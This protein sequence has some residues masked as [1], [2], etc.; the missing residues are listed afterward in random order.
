MRKTTTFRRLLDRTGPT[1]IPGVYDALSAAIAQETGFDAVAITGAGLSVTHGYPDLG[2][3]T[4]TEVVERAR[5]VVRGTSLPVLVD[6]DTG[7]GGVLNIERTVREFEAVGVAALHLEDQVTQ[8][9]CG[10]LEGIQVVSVEQMTARVRAAVAARSDPDF[11]VVARTDVRACGQLADVITRA[12][13]YRAAGADAIFL[14]DLHSRAELEVAAREIPGPKITHVSRGGRVA[15]IPPAELADMGYQAICYPL[16]PLQ[17][18]A[19]ALRTALV[20][21]RDDASLEPLYDR[22]VKPVELYELVGLTR[23]QEFARD[24][25]REEA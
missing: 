18:A 3:M 21:L 14:F 25:E 19:H 11:C 22:M 6:A 17:A 8:K 7:Y 5:A 9:R 10:L 12:H 23:A 4:L 2:L 24:Y 13:A 1:L 15:P 16:T 20:H